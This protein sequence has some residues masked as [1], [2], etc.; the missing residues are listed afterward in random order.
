MVNKVD[1][2]NIKDDFEAFAL[3][4]VLEYFGLKVELHLIATSNDLVK[5]LGKGNNLS[6]TVI[7]M[8]HGEDNAISMPPLGES[9]AANQHYKHNIFPIQLNEFLHL[10]DRLIINNGCNLGNEDFAQSFIK[11]GCKAYIG[12]NGYP[13][14]TASLFF[15]INFFYAYACLKTSIQTAH[16]LA[17]SQSEETHLFNL[18]LT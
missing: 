16:K 5:I 14:A 8:C 17:S 13:E 15:V 9:I 2:I 4:P 12:A 3:R 10:P 1:I 18:Y 11:A 6:S 7:I